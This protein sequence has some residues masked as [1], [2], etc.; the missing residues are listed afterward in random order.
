MLAT[1]CASARASGTHEVAVNEFVFGA[2][3]GGAFDV[4]DACG[5]RGVQSIELRRAGVDYLLSL[6]T[7]GMYVP[8]RVRVRCAKGAP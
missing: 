3:G 4:R 5:E 1:S 7:L 8:H 2:F 6:A